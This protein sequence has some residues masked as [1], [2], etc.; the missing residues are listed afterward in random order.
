VL[1]GPLHLVQRWGDWAGPQQARPGPS[2]LYQM[3]CSVRILFFEG[4]IHTLTLFILAYVNKN[5]IHCNYNNFT[6]AVRIW[7]SLPQHITSAPSLPVFCSCLKTYFF[8]LCYYC[9]RAREWHCYLLAVVPKSHTDQSRF[10][11]HARCINRGVY[12]TCAS[13]YCSFTPLAATG[14]SS[15]VSRSDVML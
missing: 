13:L 6:T 1:G 8:E 11:T 7:N 12:L 10:V 2:S 15:V 3:Q 9:C 5:G 4:Y 14:H